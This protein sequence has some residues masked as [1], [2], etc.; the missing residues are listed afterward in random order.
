MLYFIIA[1]LIVLLDQTVKYFVTL[2]LTPG[3]SQPLI[4]GI[5][6][7]TYVENTGAA[8]SFL[9]S[10]PWLLLA[11]S[12]VVT[13]LLIIGM[14][15]YRRKI[16]PIGMLG[17]AAILGGAVAHLIDRIVLGYVVDYLEFEFIRGF[18]VMDLADWF[19]TIGAVVFCIYYL[20][21]AKKHEQLREEFMLGKHKKATPPT[22][23]SSPDS[24]TAGTPED[25]DVS[26]QP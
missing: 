11:V 25:D 15:K 7:L 9:Q 16:D 1:A 19:I 24:E 13:L 5:I 2:Y 18:A 14:I 4:P 6:R 23:A 3:I 8:F 20:A 17:L 22:G 21:T 12:G 26:D 10:V